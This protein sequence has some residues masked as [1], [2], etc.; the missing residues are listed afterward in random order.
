MLENLR[1]DCICDVTWNKQAF[2]SLVLDEK[3]KELVEALVTKRL[4]DKSST[5]L[6]AGKGHGLVLLFH[7]GPGVGKT[8]TAEGV[9]D[10][11][12]KPLYKVTCGDI[13]AKPE[14]AEK[15]FEFVL[16]LGKTW[17]CSR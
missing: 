11:V 7:G 14:E 9:A 5:D 4:N 15:Y 6:I 8:L 10:L 3:K 2:K 1:V 13:S 17:D 12:E 16:Y